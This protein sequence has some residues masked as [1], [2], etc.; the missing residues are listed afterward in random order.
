MI[1]TYEGRLLELVMLKHGLK[2]EY[3]DGKRMLNL[4]HF[5]S[6]G[7]KKYGLTE[8]NYLAKIIPCNSMQIL[9]F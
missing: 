3:Q 6:A 8:I 1:L 5:D 7:F 2:I 4:Q 9:D